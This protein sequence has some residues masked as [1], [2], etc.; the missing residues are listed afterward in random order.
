VSPIVRTPLHGILASVE[1]LQDTTIDLFQIS[2][3]D[4]IE[5]CGRTLLDTI[6]HVLDFAKINSFAKPRDKEKG[7]N[8]AV[9]GSASTAGLSI[10]I[11]LSV[12]TEDVID[13]MHAGHEFGGKSEL[14]VANQVSSPIEV[15]LNKERVEIV[16]DIDWRSNWAFNTQSGA[17]RRI[18]MNVSY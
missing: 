10:D 14:V 15:P 6:Q 7:K 18:L 16:M 2:M 13:S 4:T 12:V 9:R 3:I 5:R 1:F 8:E 17:L 11:D